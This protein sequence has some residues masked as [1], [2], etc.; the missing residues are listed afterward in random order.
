MTIS[1]KKVASHADL[2]EFIKLPWSVYK[3]DSKWVPPLISMEK[4]RLDS[5]KGAYYKNAEVQLFL[6]YRKDRPVGRIAAH[7]NHTHNEFHN[8]QVGFFG[9][10]ECL[11][12]YEAAEALF[13]VAN[14]WLRKRGKNIIRGPMNF[15]TNDECGL[16]VHGFGFSPVVM[17]TYNPQYYESFISKYGFDKAKDL[18]AYHVHMTEMPERFERLVGKIRE[19]SNLEI[20]KMSK[21]H[22]LEDVNKV[23][24]IYNDAWQY[25]WGFVP[26]TRAEMAELAKGLK[27]I[28]DFDLVFLVYQNDKPVAFSL[29]LPDVNQVLIKVRNGRLLPFGWLKLMLG[30]GHINQVRVVTLGIVKNYKNSGIDTLLY[31]E[32]I[33]NCWKKGIHDAEMSWILEDNLRMTRPIER[34][35]G[36][37]YKTYRVYDKAIS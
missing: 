27:S 9:F 36:K 31:Y 24:D 26:M 1:V 29:S 15:S 11:P 20:R 10:F 32:T 7:I 14:D 17:M 30:M 12:D 8:D 18:Y 4:E 25:N 19:R 5:G 33:K 2:M 23:F 3:N 21:K 35:G 34:M 22:Y 16:L 13:N 6:A 28:I 37:I